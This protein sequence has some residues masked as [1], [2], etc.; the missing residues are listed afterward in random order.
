M[1]VLCAVACGGCARTKAPPPPTVATGSTSTPTGGS[2]AQET[3]TTAT[4]EHVDL[5][6]RLVTLRR[7]DGDRVTVRAGAQVRNLPQLKRGDR[8]VVI[9]YEAIAFQVLAPGEAAPSLSS[10]DDVFV[11]PLGGKPGAAVARETTL[12]A[13]ILELDRAHQRAVLRGPEG[14]R[15]TVNVHDPANFDKV[16]VGDSVA[17]TYTEAFGIEAQPPP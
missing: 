10:D 7:S 12:V 5:A 3:R 17:I 16:K 14:K 2:R 13:T 4:V 9:S 15:L 8:V 1:G 6:N 11:A